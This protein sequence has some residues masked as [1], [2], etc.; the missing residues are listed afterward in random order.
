SEESILL[1][2]DVI[3]SEKVRIEAQI[4]LLTGAGVEVLSP[5]PAA[6]VKKPK[7]D[8]GSGSASSGTCARAVKI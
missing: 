6:A 7:K 5:V 8:G 2:R 1:E 3:V 4:K